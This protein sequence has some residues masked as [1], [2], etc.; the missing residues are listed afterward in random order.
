MNIINLL[1]VSEN[2]IDFAVEGISSISLNWIGNLISWLFD[3][4]A[5]VPGGIA[6]GAI[7]FTVCLK[8]IVSPLDVYSR[9]KMKKQSLLME[10]MRPQMEKLQKQYANDKNMYNQKVLELQ[11]Q[12]GYSPLGACLPTIVSLIVF[13]VVL[14]AF[15]TY[16]N[17]SMLNTYNNLV[18]AYN[19]SV[20]VYVRTDAGENSNEKFLIS[21]DGNYRVDF[22][23]FTAYY[24]PVYD[25]E[26]KN[27]EDE[28]ARIF[29]ADAFLNK[30]EAEKFEVVISYVQINARAA[31][32][33]FYRDN[34]QS[35]SFLWIGNVW[36]PDSMFNK[37][38]PAFKDFN[39]AISR[40]VG[41]GISST[42]EES[43]NEVMHDLTVPDPAQPNKPPES[44]RYNGY[45]VLVV[46][47]IGLMFLQQF[48]MMR[49][50]K[51][52]DELSTVDGTA[53]RTNKWMMILMPVIFGAFA[54]MYSAAFS[55]YMITNT[56]FGLAMMLI[57]NKIVKVRFDKKEENQKTNG[58]RTVNRKRLK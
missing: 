49:S 51:A 29:D 54:F 24:K 32:A 31:A 21:E 11:K 18:N 47:S 19:Q 17:Y 2:F 26:H 48:I 38:I 4:F 36:Y 25:E 55:L 20:A 15:N 3:L 1:S 37:E 41:S 6:I 42:Y 57:V 16:S 46:L 9:I 58:G 53:A 44:E 12:N 56:L 27:D 14:G 40:A 45:F 5:T 33:K 52:A 28:S 8:L 50:Q 35:T 13:M 34:K 39:S 30:S 22:D 7:V 10:R 23:R 43:Y